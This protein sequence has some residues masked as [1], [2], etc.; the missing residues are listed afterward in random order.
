MRF[1]T[2]AFCDFP[3]AEALLENK[4]QNLL[5]FIALEFLLGALSPLLASGS[6]LVTPV[7][8]LLTFFDVLDFA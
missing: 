3:M 5:Q 2:E 8:L 6:F 4:L 1:D 7:L